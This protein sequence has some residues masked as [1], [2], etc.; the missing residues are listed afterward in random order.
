M[1]K[2]K[3]AI[4]LIALLLNS[5]QLPTNSSKRIAKNVV[6]YSK[7]GTLVFSA[8]VAPPRYCPYIVKLTRTK[9]IISSSRCYNVFEG[10][11][12]T[13]WAVYEAD[14]IVTKDTLISY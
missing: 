12:S 10:E 5:C 2:I 3:I 4:S 9:A 14:S 11:D 1:L 6:G 7:D 13:D 8:Y